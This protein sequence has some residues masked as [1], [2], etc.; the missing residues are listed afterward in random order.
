VIARATKAP[1]TI[2]FVAARAPAAGK[3]SRRGIRARRHEQEILKDV[4]GL[5]EGYAVNWRTAV[6]TDVG[7]D[8]AILKE[9]ERGGHNLIVMGASRRPG[10]VLFFGE[11]T[12]AVLEKSKVSLM[13]VASGAAL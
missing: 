10:E 8:H 2:L 4:T 1:V 13:I 6:L 7:A 12:A 9:A 3:K 5:A 11:T